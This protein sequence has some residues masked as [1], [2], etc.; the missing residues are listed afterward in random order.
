[1]TILEAMDD[2]HLFGPFFPGE[3]WDMWRAF[4]AAKHALPMTPA[5]HEAFVACTGRTRPP[6]RRV[7][8]CA[9]IV[10][11]RGG[12]DAIESLEVAWDAV[13]VDYRPYLSAGEWASLMLFAV[14]R[15]Q[16]GVLFARI[17]AL[18]D[19]IPLLRTFVTNR[20]R[21]T[22]EL[23]DRR[24]NLC[25]MTAS[26]RSPRGFTIARGTLNE[27]AFL[28]DESSANPDVEI[29]RALEPAMSTIPTATL[30]LLSTP[31][32][33][34]SLLWKW[35]D[36]WYGENRD[37]V[38]IWRAPT[39]VA[40]P[41]IDQAVIDAAYEDDP[42]SAAAEFGAEF[43]TDV[44][45]FIDAESVDGAIPR[46]VREREPVVGVSYVAFLDPSGGR[47]DSMVLAIAHHDHALGA[48]LLDCVREIVPPFSPDVACHEAAQTMQRYGLS[49]CTSDKYGGVWPQAKL[50]EFGVRCAQSAEPKSELYLRLLPLLNSGKIMLLDNRKLR[51]QLLSLERRTSRSGRDSVAEPSSSQSHDDVCNAACG[52]VVLAHCAPPIRADCF[53]IN[54][55]LTKASYFRESV[56]G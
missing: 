18:F 8:R 7:K 47:S 43:R 45:G 44:T 35:C 34:T 36:Q 17:E 31:Y 3:S 48:T 9:A 22:L 38:L 30:T 26:N 19:E 12:K 51:A 23:G 5:M 15:K 40:N 4:L 11:R 39:W 20:T 50:A 21:D 56:W 29:V 13:F 42:V 32:S 54:D 25:V 28:R 24:V 1:V 14:D 52:A 49:T 55:S 53:A 2:P 27:S 41:T 37:D 16:A 6:A 46:G 33:R 10:G